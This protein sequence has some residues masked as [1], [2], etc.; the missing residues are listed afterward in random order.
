MSKRYQ[1]NIISASPVA[2]TENYE[3]SS[4]SGVWSLGEAET[5]TRAGLW[6]TLGN[7]APFGLFGGSL[8]STTTTIEKLVLTSAGNATD[9]GDLTVARGFCSN[10]GA[11]ST[12]RGIFAG[13]SDANGDRIDVMDYVTLTT[14]GNATDFG[15]L[16][17]AKEKMAGCSSET[18][19]IF[20][21]GE[22]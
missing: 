21:G 12:T 18:R 22:S 10:G 5:F 13:G 20:A 11:A 7:I 8:G 15:N 6:P 9:F 1:G 14:T 17:A 16:I 4:A 2:P 19:G 3:N